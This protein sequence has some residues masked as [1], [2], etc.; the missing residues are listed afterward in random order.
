M[1]SL[2]NEIQQ[3]YNGSNLDVLKLKYGAELVEKFIE[4]QL[5]IDCNDFAERWDPEQYCEKHFKECTGEPGSIEI[6]HRLSD[7]DAWRSFGERLAALDDD[8]VA[9]I[10]ALIEYEE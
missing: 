1:K 10:E 2:K 3:A 8:E 5:C 4:N 9:R 7:Q 6:P